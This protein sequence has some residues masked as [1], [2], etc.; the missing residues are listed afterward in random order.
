MQGQRWRW[1]T[2]S[3]SVGERDLNFD[4]WFIERRVNHLGRFF[5]MWVRWGP[6]GRTGVVGGTGSHLKPAPELRVE[7]AG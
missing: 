1:R 6:V 3:L 4:R 7:Y 2:G 5:T